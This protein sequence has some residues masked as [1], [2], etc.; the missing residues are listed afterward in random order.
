MARDAETAALLAEGVASLGLDGLPWSDALRE[1]QAR[2]VNLRAWCPELALPDVSDAALLA[3][4]DS[5]LTPLF[6]GKAR[7][8]DLGSGDLAHALHQQLDYAQRRALDEHAPSSSPCP[9]ACSASSTTPS[10]NRRCWQ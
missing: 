7:L 1:W 8:S 2:V 4:A 5:W 6:D 3:S 9:A 10:V